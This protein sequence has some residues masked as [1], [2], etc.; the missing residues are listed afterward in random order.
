M[1]RPKTQPT[2][3]DKLESQF[4]KFD[5]DVKRLT[6]DAM[7][8]VKD[9][10][11]DPQ[12]KLSAKQIQKEPEHYLKPDR[13]INDGQKFNEKFRED[14]NY[15]KEYVQF[16]AENREIIGEAIELW[17][18]PFGGV[19]AEFWKVPVN[20]PVWGPRYLAEQIR[21]CTYHRL[22][23]DQ[24]QMIGADGVGSYFGTMVADKVIHRLTAE[25]V[26]DRVSVFMGKAA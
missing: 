9:P 4:D 1:S 24:K 25:P 7:N 6:L 21:K 19:G 10:G 26:N 3:M 23:M 5:Q 8:E 2:E 14:W 20:K 15:A 17:T 13:I 16:I 22:M 18:H 12:T 11:F